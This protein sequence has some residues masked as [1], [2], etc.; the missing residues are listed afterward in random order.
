[1]RISTK[2]HVTRTGQNYPKKR[3]RVGNNEP[4]LHASKLMPYLQKLTVSH[5]RLKKPSTNTSRRAVSVL[6]ARVQADQ[7]NFAPNSAGQAARTHDSSSVKTRLRLVRLSPPLPSLAGAN[8]TG[9]RVCISVRRYAYRLLQ[10]FEY[11]V[12]SEYGSVLKNNQT[13]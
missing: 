2:A 8:S 11:Y 13:L 7:E 5:M 10:P 4:Q 1:L 9:N 3:R 12:S 6:F